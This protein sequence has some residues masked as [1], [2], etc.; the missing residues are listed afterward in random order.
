MELTVT[1]KA[2]AWFENELELSKGDSLRIFGKYGGATNV[3]VGM[4]TGIEI[5]GPNKPMIEKELNGITYFI[6]QTD[7][8]FFG[9]YHLNVDIDDK[10]KE[11]TYTYQ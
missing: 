2:Q 10:L 6:E 9:N 7:E 5:T 11:P 3:H 4:S 1:E 8:W